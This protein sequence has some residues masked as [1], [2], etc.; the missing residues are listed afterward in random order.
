MKRSYVI[1]KIKKPI[2]VVVMLMAIAS[3]ERPYLQPWPPDAARTP[4]DVWSYYF[5][6][7]GFLETVSSNHIYHSYI[8]DVSGNGMF[9]SATD[10]AVHSDPQ[11]AVKNFTNGIWNPTNIPNIRYG[12]NWSGRQRFTSPW[13]NAYEGIRICNVFLENVDNSAMID[14]ISNPARAN[15]RTYYKGLA[16]YWR[17]WLQF[18]ILRRYGPFPIIL[19]SLSIDDVEELRTP[20]GTM[21]E[22]FNQIISDCDEAIE[23]LPLLWDD[24]NWHRANKTAAQFLKARASLYY[25]SPLYQGN[26]EEFGLPANSVGDVDRWILAANAA[27]AAIDDNPFYNLMTVTKFNRPFAATN[28]YNNR[29]SLVGNLSQLEY[30]WGTTRSNTYSAGYEFYNLPAGVQGCNGYTNPTQEMVDAFEVINL[31]ANGRPVTGATAV[32]FDWNNPVHAANP[33]A[34]RDP[35]FY[36]SI[37]YN[38]TL[39]GNDAAR[40]YLIDTY[41]GGVHRN[42]LNPTSTKTGYYYRKWLSEDFYAYVTG[43]YTAASRSRI[44]F[45]FAELLLNYAEAMNEAYGPDVSHPEGALRG[46]G[47]TARE[48]LNRVRTRVFMP[49]IPTGLTQAEMRERIKH[50]RRIELCFENGHRFYDLRRWKQGEVLGNP[51]HGIKITPAGIDPATNRPILPYTYEVVK[52]EDRV[53]ADKMYW[54]PIPYSEIVKYEGKLKQNPGWGN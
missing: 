22:C 47:S 25:A 14:D 2:M 18:D 36:A 5:F 15:D 40:A 8:N 35:R 12:G 26:F 28:T 33:Y 30:I 43:Q 52:V 38:G 20:R 7:R 16:Y 3:C 23:R 9:A 21:E 10:E 42:P 44:K 13:S 41:E 31:D 49:A 6:T 34:N 17:A 29:I 1:S 54:W 27:K 45:R 11:G 37:N 48:A 19:K 50:E 53:W 24:N 39:W 32:P 46:G 4:E 51:I